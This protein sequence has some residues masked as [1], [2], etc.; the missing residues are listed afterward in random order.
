MAFGPLDTITKVPTKHISPGPQ[1]QLIRHGP[2]LQ[3]IDPSTVK[4]RYLFLFSDLILLAKP[5]ST[6]PSSNTSSSYGHSMITP[7]SPGGASSPPTS[8]LI[9]KPTPRSFQP[10][11]IMP[12]VSA[13]LSMAPDPMTKDQSP[14]SILNSM[15]MLIDR[16]AGKSG[17]RVLDEL[18]QGHHVRGD[19][20]S[21]ITFLHKN[22][23]L[24]PDTILRIITEASPL[25]STSSSTSASSSSSSLELATANSPLLVPYLEQLPYRG[26]PIVDCVRLLLILLTSSA[27]SPQIL[28]V[29]S[30]LW[31]QANPHTGV[32]VPSMVDLLHLAF[33]RPEQRLGI[34][35]ANF[36]NPQ[37]PSLDDLTSLVNE[38][39]EEEARRDLGLGERKDR[40]LRSKSLGLDAPV[41]SRGGR[42]FILES[43]PVRLP[44][45]QETGEM[46]RVRIP[47][48]DPYL[49]LRVITEKGLTAQPSR[50]TFSPSE[51]LSCAFTLTGHVLGRRRWALIP[52]GPRA[53]LYRSHHCRTLLIERPFMRW[54]FRL[55]GYAGM[56]HAM[57]DA[58]RRKGYILSVDT[59]AWL[60]RWMRL[61]TSQIPPPS[62]QDEA[63]GSRD[64]SKDAALLQA[65]LSHLDPGVALDFKE[66]VRRLMA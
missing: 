28:R 32:D 56:D 38:A 42:P 9:E 51:P 59:K 23:I 4:Q 2:V 11:M 22:P 5:L 13:R 41:E 10:R 27:S 64:L 45:D 19:T 57:G 31:C 16:T 61:L 55:E 62:Q 53:F 7:V 12:L 47:S 21:I 54:T 30:H 18:I 65:P 8:P 36:P 26:V 40:Q 34:S 15:A 48:P 44:M 29:F 25:S 1:R 58:A 63:L 3:V 14:P 46:H 52:E 39:R 6:S 66:M 35:G 49:T 37:C 17:S 60:D 50:L 20:A 24:P 33:L 43:Y